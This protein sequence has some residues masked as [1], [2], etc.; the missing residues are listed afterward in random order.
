MTRAV[1]TGTAEIGSVP[2]PE[3][4]A[5]RRRL[6]ESGEVTGAAY[7]FL[8]PALLLIGTLFF[9][10]VLAAL[11]LSFTDF[12]IYAIGD[13]DNTRWVGVRNY[14]QLL[15]TPLFWTA[16]R[17]TF[18]FALIGGP[19][20]IATS[21]GAALLLNTRLV[22]FQGFFRTVYFAPFVTTLVAVAIVWRY[23][24]H[25]VWPAQ[26]RTRLPRARADRLAG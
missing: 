5:P 14:G 4:L 10:P 9:L 7:L 8:A 24:Y 2:P 16:L 15:E 17:N 11:A 13:L 22:R 25:T 1:A 6:R 23:L 3:A 19:L 21:L 18:Y 20:S 26:L 12:D